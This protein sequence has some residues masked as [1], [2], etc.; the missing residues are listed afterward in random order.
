MVFAVD[1]PTSPEGSLSA[2]G[3]L[4]GNV[5]EGLLYMYMND[6]EDVRGLLAESW[7][8]SGDGLTYSFR[9]RDGMCFSDGAQVSAEVRSTTVET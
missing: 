8:V 5:F 6:P 1:L 3:M 7:S 9:L 4:W 2:P